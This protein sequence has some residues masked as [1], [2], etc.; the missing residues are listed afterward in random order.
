[1]CVYY[2]S[3]TQSAQFTRSRSVLEALL[4][5]RPSSDDELNNVIA[6]LRETNGTEQ[7]DQQK[8]ESDEQD[9]NTIESESNSKPKRTIRDLSPFNSNFVSIYH[10]V[11]N[12]IESTQHDNKKNSCYC[13]VYIKQLLNEFM[14]YSFIWVS[15]AMRDYG[16]TRMTNGVVEVYNKYRKKQLK[17]AVP[18]VYINKSVGLVDGNCKKY[19][20]T[21]EH[22]PIPK[23]A[24]VQEQYVDDEDKH[25]CQETWL[26]PNYGVEKPSYQSKV[27]P[28]HFD[29]TEVNQIRNRPIDNDLTIEPIKK[30]KIVLDVGQLRNSRFCHVCNKSML[31]FFLNFN[32]DFTF[33]VLCYN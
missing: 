8:L 31:N 4:A 26:K 16:A 5:Q 32:I 20:K 13:P 10:E 30:A 12:E 22:P 29:L 1:M 9:D 3:P 27:D 19:L 15:F 18:D 25:S 33:N 7:S 6:E 23:E 2:L 24:N 17:C 21:I 11:M 28:K 14:P